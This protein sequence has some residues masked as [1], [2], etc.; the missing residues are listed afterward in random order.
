MNYLRRWFYFCGTDS[1]K[2]WQTGVLTSSAHGEMTCSR[3]LSSLVVP[4]LWA[5]VMYALPGMVPTACSLLCGLISLPVSVSASVSPSVTLCLCVCLS[6]SNPCTHSFMEDRTCGC[7]GMWISVWKAADWIPNLA[8]MGCELLRVRGCFQHFIS[9]SVCHIL[10]HMHFG[11]Q[12]LLS[13]TIMVLFHL[14]PLFLQPEI[15]SS[16]ICAF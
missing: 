14:V 11:H 10:F 16:H 6:L 2:W 15:P 5:E 8:V 12:A 3:L 9:N 4:C 13:S 7:I 1:A